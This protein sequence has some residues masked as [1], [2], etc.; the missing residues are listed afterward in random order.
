[1]LRGRNPFAF[2]TGPWDPERRFV[3]SWLVSPYV[4]GGIR[5]LLSL[6][7]FTT[8]LFNIGYNCARPAQGG[9]ATSRAAFSYFTVL[10]YWGLAFYLLFAAAHTLLYARRRG[11][12][13]LATTWPRPLQALHAVLYS[14]VTTFPLLVV[15]VFWALLASPGVL[16]T[17]YAAWS[18][19]SQHVL[20]AAFALFEILVPRTRPPPWTHLPFL[21]ALLA[22]YLALAYLTRAT[23]GFYTYTFLDAGKQG[24]LVA[25]Y[26]FGIAIGICI[27][28]AV[29]WGLVWLRRWVTEDKLGLRGVFSAHGAP[30]PPLDEESSGGGSRGVHKSGHGDQELAEVNSAV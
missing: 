25:A 17:P 16:A 2:G 12:Y 1:M 23:K 22:L 15:I 5:A 27:L 8:L 19:V 30:P 4:L 3:T 6:Y 18:N 29:V 10:S 26:V 9:C 11:A 14:T 13:P 24:P 28:F 7:A 21:I 20:N